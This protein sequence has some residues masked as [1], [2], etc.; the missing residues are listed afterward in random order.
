[1]ARRIAAG[2]MRHTVL[3]KEHK[4]DAGT[5]AYDTYGQ[6]STSTTAWTTTWTTRAKIDQLSGNES[7]IA[8]Q[9]YPA[10]SHRV[11]VDYNSTLASTGATRRA[12]VFGNRWLHIGAV[13]DADLEHCQLELLCGEER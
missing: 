9:L 4:I 7:A 5:T 11:V 1:M 2:E 12:V 6:V 8:R 3:I 13:I 10:A